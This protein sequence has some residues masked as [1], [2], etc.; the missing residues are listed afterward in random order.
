MSRFCFAALIALIASPLARAGEGKMEALGIYS[1][2]CAKVVA[3]VLAKVPGV[4]DPKVDLKTRTA[5]FMAKDY[6]AF[7]DAY[8]ALVNAGLVCLP[9]YDLA[10]GEKID[11][12]ARFFILGKMESK[13]K[14]NVV[15]VKGVHC[16]CA[17][18]QKVIAGLF[19][20]A[21]VTFTGTGPQKDL[22]ITGKDLSKADIINA[23]FD[24]GLHGKL[25]K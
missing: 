7:R 21:K 1:D 22:T 3:D 13:G 4:S 10:G 11:P 19:K 23:L 14:T 15:K 9:Y 16:C 17:D 25:D 12:K 20:N 6:A 18:C 5:T 24:A 2:K 8:L